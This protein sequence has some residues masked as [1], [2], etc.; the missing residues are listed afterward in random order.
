MLSSR[1]VPIP[2]RPLRRSCLAL[3]L[4]LAGP[5]LGAPAAAAP[6]LAPPDRFPGA[7]RAYLVAVDGRE[8]WARDADRPLP[9]A[10]L[11]KLMT[12]LVALEGPWDPKALVT[13]SPRAGRATGARVGLQAG[14]RLR[15]EDLLAAALVA[16]GNDACLALAEHAA[17]SEAAFVARMNAR[18][19]ALG[20]RATRFENACGHDGPGQRASARD[21]LVIARAALRHPEV[22]RLGAVESMTIRTEAGRAL[23]LK[24]TNALRRLAGARGVK[25]GWTPGAGRCVVA[26]V[27]RGG[28]ELLLVLLDAGD[29]WWAAAGL[30]EQAFAE[31]GRGG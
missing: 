2:R 6:P 18:A 26:L 20:L 24:T 19:A 21:L 8:L 5:A 10:S 28:V 9:P 11:T 29:R 31:A 7:A 23:P 3:C 27:E 30:V 1:S 17:G 16:S 4:A 14:D 22:R 13:V 15:A 12:A 25:T